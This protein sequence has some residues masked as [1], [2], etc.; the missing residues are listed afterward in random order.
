MNRGSLTVLLYTVIAINVNGQILQP[1]GGGSKK[2]S[3]SELI[4]ITNVNVDYYRP[5]VNGREGK[6]WGNVVHYGFADLGFGTTKAAPWR[7]GANEN[8]T[9]EFSTDVL[10]EGKVL[11]AGKYGFFIA[12]G[13]TKAAVI[14]SKYNTAWGSFY[15]D[16][17]DDALRAEVPVLKTNELVER[18][19]YEF[20][21]QTDESAT[22]SL[23]WE[24]VKIPFK[25]SVDLKKEQLAI[26]RKAINSGKF[27]VFWQNV[28]DAA[29]YCLINN[30]NLE[31]ALGWSYRSINDFFG[32]SNFLTLSTYA[33]LLER[34]NR[35]KEADSVMQK[36]LP[37]ATLLQL[38]SYARTLTRMKENKRAFEAYKMNY[39]KY[40]QDGNTTIGMV[41]GYFAIGDT[42]EALKYA[43]KALEIFT[44]SNS[45]AFIN[46]LIDDMKAGKDINK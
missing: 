1:A 8:T 33:G 21:D 41:R 13:E 34:L 40:P 37:L 46:K 11:P 26:Y 6:I 12:M 45:R 28:R 32:E 38:N 24:R 29:N 36:A 10:I 43:E 42:K 22:V 17:K 35:K 2:A 25:I 9:I 16:P 31:E 20:S 15:Y 14:F 30:I 19:R 23:L 5:A 39:D 7:A 27:Y 18:L 44:D 3:V 4:G